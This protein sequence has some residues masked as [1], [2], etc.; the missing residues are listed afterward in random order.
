MMKMLKDIKKQNKRF[1][2]Y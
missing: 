1:S 2:L